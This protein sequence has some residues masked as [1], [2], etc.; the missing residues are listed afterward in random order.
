[1]SGVEA[2]GTMIVVCLAVVGLVALAAWYAER[3][4][5]HDEDD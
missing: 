4:N 1:M 5:W 2:V 3:D